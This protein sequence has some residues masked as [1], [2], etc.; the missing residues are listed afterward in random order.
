MEL[1]YFTLYLRNYMRDHG[2]D[3]KEIESQI[4]KDNAETAT[5]T[6][7]NY[8]KNGASV[9]GA[10]E[11]ALEDLFIGIGLSIMEVSE[12]ILEK[13]FSERINITEPL[14]LDF[15]AQKMTE[16]KSIWESFY[17]TEGLGLNKELVEADKGKLHSRIDQFLKSHGL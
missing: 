10:T 2:F 5:L 9:A 7:E 3:S 17:N 11:A 1:N 15:W 4:A 13:D 16:D 8:R 6:Y 14:V 12:D